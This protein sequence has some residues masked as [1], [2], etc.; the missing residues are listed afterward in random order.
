VR[1]TAL[2]GAGLLRRRARPGDRRG[3]GLCLTE[4][5]EPVLDRVGTEVSAPT[6]V[7]D[8]LD[9]GERARLLELPT[10]LTGP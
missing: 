1:P 5:A 4:Q 3:R 10:L 6:A 7:L 9:A 2:E 8:R